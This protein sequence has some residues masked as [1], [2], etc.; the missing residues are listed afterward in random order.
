MFKNTELSIFCSL[1]ITEPPA[2]FTELLVK[3]VFVEAAPVGVHIVPDYNLHQ[4]FS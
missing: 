4:K 2:F 3:A 1:K